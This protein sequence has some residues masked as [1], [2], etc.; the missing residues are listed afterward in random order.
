M[1]KISPIMARCYEPIL[2]PLLQGLRQE[3]CALVHLAKHQLEHNTSQ[4]TYLDCCCGTGGLLHMLQKQEADN[5]ISMRCIGLDY[6]TDM[7]HVGH[8][9]K[10]K[11]HH[12]AKNQQSQMLWVQGNALQ[13]PFSKQSID[14]AS[15]CMALHTLSQDNAETILRELRRVAKKIIIADYCL[16]ER[17]ISLPATWLAHGIEALV[18]GE[19]YRAYK[20]FMRYGALEGL[21]QRMGFVP[22]LRRSVLGGAGTVVVLA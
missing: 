7:L 15:I 22:S 19:H 18:G 14:I 8:K 16:A 20:E 21:L 13:L 17:N 6:N 3:V 4:A 12:A 5:T 11:E 1:E 9:K 2:G 10:Y